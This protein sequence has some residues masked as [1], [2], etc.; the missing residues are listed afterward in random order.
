MKEHVDPQ[1]LAIL[2][3]LDG[4]VERLRGIP[5]AF[6]GIEL[7]AGDDLELLLRANGPGVDTFRI[8]GQNEAAEYTEL[9]RLPVGIRYSVGEGR[10]GCTS[11]DPT[12]FSIPCRRVRCPADAG[13]ATGAIC[14]GQFRLQAKA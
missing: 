1:L 6:G 14:R 8:L 11:S 2:R 13:G 5:V 4:E 9:R 3:E 12:R 10:E 7:V